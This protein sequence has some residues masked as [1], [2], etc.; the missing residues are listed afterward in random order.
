VRI[1]LKDVFV[2]TAF[3]AVMAWC[4]AEAGIDN[5]LFW[6]VLLASLVSCW[7]FFSLAKTGH[8]KWMLFQPV[9]LFFALP[10]VRSMAFAYLIGALFVAAI[11][12]TALPPLR[13]RTLV[14]ILMGCL[15]ASFVG[16]VFTGKA[17]L[18]RLQALRQKYP[19]VSLAHRLQYEKRP[20]NFA[21][22]DIEKMASGVAQELASFEQDLGDRDWRR[23]SL[24][25]LHDRSYELFVRA[26]GFGVGRMIM[27]SPNDELIA[28]SPLRNI[29][30]NEPAETSNVSWRE[31]WNAAWNAAKIE[32]LPQLHDLSR[33]D[34]LDPGGFG[35][36][37]LPLKAVAGF[38][39][40][41]LHVPMSNHLQEPSMWALERLELVSLLRFDQPR[42]YVLDHLPRMDQLSSDNSPT[43]PLDEFEAAAL[44]RLFAAEDVVFEEH[45]DAYR[46][47]GSLRA[48]RQCLDC[49]TATRG[50]LLG[51][52][53][54]VLRRGKAND[55][56]LGIGSSAPTIDH[57]LSGGN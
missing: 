6:G 17:E 30:F 36:I 44:P 11:I 4:A 31:D 22:A 2:V 40:H 7:V 29:A 51:A 18:R 23:W 20:R 52:F 13:T 56:T 10:I 45:G 42:V 9:L 38:M 50:E 27:G 49:H 19:V 1:S 37:S 8:T 35:F 5:G 24:S 53:S 12:C 57:G 34:F 21:S 3:T 41:A 26:S 54:Y 28:R 48:A 39:E 46:M 47:L 55:S 43:R 32:N 15:T 33:N 25:R 14:A 16:A